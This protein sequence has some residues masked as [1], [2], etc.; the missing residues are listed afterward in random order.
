[1]W[2]EK[3][4]RPDGTIQP[5]TGWW[6]GWHRGDLQRVLRTACEQ[7]EQREP[8]FKRGE[9]CYG[10]GNSKS[11]HQSG[12]PV[13]PYTTQENSVIACYIEECRTLLGLSPIPAN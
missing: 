9:L 7:L 6:R 12:C 13:S 11:H 4:Q 1:M 2:Y 3:F 8:R 10:C 5:D